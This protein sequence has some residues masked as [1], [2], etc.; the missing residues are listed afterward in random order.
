MRRETRACERCRLYLRKHG[1]CG[2]DLEKIECWKEQ[3]ESIKHVRLT[4]TA[5]D[6]RWPLSTTRPVIRPI[7]SNDKR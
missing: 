1:S 4:G 5:T 7:A 6:S 3:V 2:E